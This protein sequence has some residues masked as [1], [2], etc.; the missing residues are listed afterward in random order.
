MRQ[1]QLRIETPACRSRALQARAA[2]S[3]KSA[4]VVRFA[5]I[6]LMIPRMS[7]SLYPPAGPQS[8]GQVLDS[9]FP[10]FPDVAR[11]LP[12]LWRAV[13][14]RRTTAEHL[15]HRIGSAAQV[16]RRRQSL[17]GSALYLVGALIALVHVRARCCIASTASQRAAPRRRV[18][19]LSRGL[20]PAARAISGS[21]LLG[22]A[23]AVRSRHS[24]SAGACGAR[25]HS[26]HDRR[27]G[28][29][30]LIAGVLLA[31]P[32]VYLVHV[33]SRS[34]RRRC[35]SMAR[36]RG[37]PCATCCG[38]SGAAGGERPRCSRSPVV[39][40]RGVLRSWRWSSWA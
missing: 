29:P 17:C 36:A 26:R 19:E 21:L 35:C 11:Q 6:A 32:L 5:A 28:A 15:L 40:D 1:Q 30:V 3:V 7:Q 13:D 38:S 8:I 2:P 31:I 10:H 25:R 27:T 18:P 20:A 33:H 14:D 23:A 4:L 39:A 9:G 37:R 22:R 34:L 12:A 24:C 16:V